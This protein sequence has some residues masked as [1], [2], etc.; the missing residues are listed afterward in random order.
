MKAALALVFLLCAGVGFAADTRT[1]RPQRSWIL[2]K[3]YIRLD[4]WARANGFQWKWTSKKDVL[5]WNSGWRLEFTTDSKRMSINGVSILLSESVRRGA[6]PMVAA[7]DFTTAIQPVLFPPKGSPGS[8]V[9]HICIDPGHGGKDPG[10]R[11]GREQEK[12]YTLLLAQELGAQLRQAGYTVS[13]TRSG[14]TFIDLPDRPAIA[15]RRG[16]DLLIS[17]HFNSAPYTSSQIG[18]VEVFCMTPQKASSTNARGA[19]GNSGAYSG[20]NQNARNM[21]LAYQ[22]QKAVVRATQL[23][24]RGVKRAR[25][26]ILREATMPTVLV[27]AGFM[28]NPAEARKIYSAAWRKQLAQSIVSGVASYRK[29]VE[30]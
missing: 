14:D 22:I 10:N 30:P 6:A 15:R 1:V 9:R 23:E 24:D 7:L 4:E 26:Q 16:A 13:Y 3:E 21:A 25:F 28:S 19:G 2:G 27:E 8:R 5:V 18:G 20:N 29:A 12:K 17:L 11:E